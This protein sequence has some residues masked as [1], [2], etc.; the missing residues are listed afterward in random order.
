MDAET[1]GRLLHIDSD[2]EKQNAVFYAEAAVKYL[3]NAGCR[4]DYTDGL[5]KA[6]VVTITAKMLTNPD[7]LTNLGENSGL[8]INA[9]IAQCRAAQSMKET[10]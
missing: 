1:L 6:L 7:L 8:A 2:E 3:I 9:M 10:T 4:E 5:F